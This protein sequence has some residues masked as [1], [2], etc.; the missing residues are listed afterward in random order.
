MPIPVALA[1]IAASLAGGFIAGIVQFFASRAGT[2]LAGLGLTF[3]GVKSFEAFL[4]FFISDIQFA[5]SFASQGSGGGSGPNYA[6][7]AMQMAAYIGLFDGINIIL[8]GY[9]AAGSLVGMRVL[10]GRMK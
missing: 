6:A 7:I 10:M 2:M 5:L 8:S 3:V 1:P 9:M 4:G